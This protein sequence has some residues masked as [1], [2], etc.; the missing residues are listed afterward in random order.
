MK[1]E[2]GKAR[3]DKEKRRGK[4]E[5]R[6]IWNYRLSKAEKEQEC[7]VGFQH[8]AHLCPLLCSLALQTTTPKL[9]LEQKVKKWKSRRES[10]VTVTAAAASVINEPVIG[11]LIC[12]WLCLQQSPPSQ[13]LKWRWLEEN[14]MEETLPIKWHSLRRIASCLQ[15]AAAWHDL[16]LHFPNAKQRADKQFFHFTAA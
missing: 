6:L 2:K 4:H 10:S 11:A 12:R 9:A 5:A 16:S 3:R 13:N 14:I 1:K 8:S 7:A 15:D